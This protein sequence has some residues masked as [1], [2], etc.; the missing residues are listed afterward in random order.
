MM[1]SWLSHILVILIA[2]QSVMAVADMHPEHQADSHEHASAASLAHADNM[3]TEQELSSG[4][5][6]QHCC[7]CQSSQSIFLPPALQ[8]SEAR[9]NHLRKSAPITLTSQFF[10]PPRA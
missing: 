10:K 5:D 7:H 8:G 3:Q 2:L 4:V 9:I 6:C 1:T